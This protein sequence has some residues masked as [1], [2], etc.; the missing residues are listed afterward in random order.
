MGLLAGQRR[1]SSIGMRQN[2]QRQ[3]DLQCHRN[4]VPRLPDHTATSNPKGRAR[5]IV[6]PSNLELSDLQYKTTYKQGSALS[7]NSPY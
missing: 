1:F 4:Q 6:F 5:C 7:L 2:N 3:D